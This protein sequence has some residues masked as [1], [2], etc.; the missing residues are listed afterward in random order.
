L[1][2]PIQNNIS[3]EQTRTDMDDS[4][5]IR[6]HDPIICAGENISCLR[7]R[8]HCDRRVSIS[9]IEMT[10]NGM[11]DGINLSSEA[12]FFFSL[13]R[14]NSLWGPPI[15]QLSKCRHFI[16]LFI[17]SLGPFNDVV[18]IFYYLNIA[19]RISMSS[20]Q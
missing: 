1:P 11:D 15:I 13:L 10:G 17:Y 8:G 16:Y 12:G 20:E 9:L 5:G 4:C 7:T 6:N 3:T 18:S 19:L 2:L 14:P